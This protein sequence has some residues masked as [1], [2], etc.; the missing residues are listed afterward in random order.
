MTTP[1][2]VL[3]SIA[4]EEDSRSHVHTMG[5]DSQ[6][7]VLCLI[8]VFNTMM[9]LPSLWEDAPR[10]LLKE[11]LEWRRVILTGRQA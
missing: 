2:Q 1:W 8:E 11:H 10:V 5:R 4:C 3:R 6:H 9:N 7:R